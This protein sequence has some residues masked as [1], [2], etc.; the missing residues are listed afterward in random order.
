MADN[1]ILFAS[2]G[3]IAVTGYSRKD[4]ILR[5]CRFLQGEMTDYTATRR[6]KQSIDHCEETVELLLNY[7]KNG[8]PFWN[9]LYCA[10]LFDERGDIS[11]F[12]GG[13]IDVSTTIHSRSDILKVLGTNNEHFDKT[14]EL[15]RR[16]LAA[17]STQTPVHSAKTLFS[18]NFRKYNTSTRRPSISLSARP[19]ISVSK[20][21]GMEPELMHKLGKLSFKTQIEA[22]YTAFSKV[23]CNFFLV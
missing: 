21:P 19:S 1:P 11:F 9:L 8:E 3:F 13:Q 23:Y 4:I 5:N 10:P 7:R 14:P 12:I 16:N 17:V 2:D 6:L 15:S 22:F 18:R 20:E